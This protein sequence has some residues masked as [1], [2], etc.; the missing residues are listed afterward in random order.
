MENSTKADLNLETSKYEVSNIPGKFSIYT[1]SGLGITILGVIFGMFYYEDLGFTISIIGLLLILFNFYFINSVKKPK[2]INQIPSKYLV[3]FLGAV[4]LVNYLIYNLYYGLILLA[5]GTSLMLRSINIT[6]R[7]LELKNDVPTRYIL[8]IPIII[9][10]TISF[11]CIFMFPIAYLLDPQANIIELNWMIGKIFGLILNIMIYSCWFFP[12]LT[13]INVSLNADKITKVR[14]KFITSGIKIMIPS[15][16]LVVFYFIN[17][18]VTFIL[19]PYIQLGGYLM[20]ISG[21]ILI[22]SGLVY[23][24]LNKNKN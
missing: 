13:C 21:S 20:F 11:L 17:Q 6:L 1:L 19:N 10:G 15:I 18:I 2:T 23:Y 7:K 9:T 16:I 12:I 14:N 22:I 5:F 24:F 4:L 8:L 3:A